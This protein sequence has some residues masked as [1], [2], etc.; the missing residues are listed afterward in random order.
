MISFTRF[1]ARGVAK[2]YELQGGKA[3]KKPAENFKTGTYETV[4]VS[5][6]GELW[7]FVRELG[8]GDFL[9]AG[10]HQTQASGHC[11]LGAGDIRRTK[12]EFPFQSVE[13]GLCIIDSDNLDELN[14]SDIDSFATALEK[15]IGEADY[16]LSP[17]ASSGITVN[18]IV[19]PIK[20][21]HTFVFVEDTTSIPDALSILHKR[22]ILL[23]Y[24][25]PFITK[26]GAILI[27]SLVDLAMKTP[28]QP[29]FEGG[30]ILCDGIT[31]ER[32]ILSSKP[33]DVPKFL[34]ITPLT[35]DEE[36]L[37]ETKS[38]K[39]SEAV[40]AEAACKRAAW[41][42]EREAKMIA[43]GCAPEEAKRIIDEALSGDRPVLSS[44]FEIHTDKFGIKTVR[45]LLASAVKYHEATCSD[46]LDPE[47]GT[48]KAKIYTLNKDGRPAINSHAHGGGVFILEQELFRE[49][50]A[51]DVKP[52]INMITTENILEVVDRTDSGNVASLYK[53]T[54]GDL[55]YIPELKSFMAWVDGRWK[56]DPSGVHA[57]EMALSVAAGYSKHAQKL[58]AEAMKPH[59]SDKERDRIQAAA[60][61]IENW[62][63]KC[64]D[65]HKLDAMQD[66]AKRDR[67]F[68]VEASKLDQDSEL[69]GVQNGVVHLRTGELRVD[70]REDLVTKRCTVDYNP[71]ATA[72]RW[73]LFISEITSSGGRL[74]GGE[75]Q[76]KKRPH[77]AEY[78]QKLLGYGLTGSTAEQVLIIMW[79]LGSNGK[80]VLLD[81][82][83]KAV[84]EYAETVSPEILMAT[85][86]D[87]G[88]DSATPSIRKLAGARLAISGE[89]KEGQKLEASIVK[90]HTGGGFITA[91]G[92]HQ[93][94]MTFPI[95][96]KLIL[97]TNTPPPVDHMDLAMQGRIN[98]IPFDMRWNRPGEV[99]PDP[100]LPDAQKDLMEVLGAELEGILLW[101]VQGAVAY[102]TEGL[103]PPAEVTS[104][105]RNYLDSQDSLKQWLALYEKCAPAEGQLAAVLQESYRSFC[106]EEDLQIKVDSPAGLGKKLKALG[107]QNK[108]SR[109]GMH[110]GLREVAAT[111]GQAKVD[112]EDE[113]LGALLDRVFGVSD[114]VG[115]EARGSV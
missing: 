9:T 73:E 104:T 33:G 50:A 95:T 13:P 106:S 72:E 53:E 97:M 18:G 34:T 40:V 115:P 11:G 56:M 76:R 101:L 84:G 112:G 94:P 52:A 65:K 47:D 63:S 92:L 54:S 39:L 16:V 100:N 86:F 83:V 31:Q 108:K 35:K 7:G 77:L 74:V 4:R 110:Y 45:E 99:D 10:V 102:F 103:H 107:Y 62:S 82:V 36:R 37:V 80:N 57:H 46:P 109:D 55:R 66:L 88:A 19:G 89:S 25:W 43:N 114:D 79:G 98:M 85:K 81:T 67:R 96:H 60:K 51:E 70:S 42:A 48:G 3:V 91:R 26:N 5:S 105:T 21:M 90:R 17:S 64:R 111:E 22:S 61:S 28:N 27:R 14:L 1:H 12:E 8:P 75:L 44:D 78:L 87:N 49:L 41:R 93:S 29:C 59:L 71:M 113:G 15:L 30:A 69:L 68:V 20:G 23:G 32:S 58:S 24:A 6:I 2:S 38:R